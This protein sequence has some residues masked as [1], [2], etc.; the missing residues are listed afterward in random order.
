MGLFT[1]L[2]TGWFTKKAI[3]EYKSWPASEKLTFWTGLVGKCTINGTRLKELR[4]QNGYSREELAE[5]ICVTQYII[6]GWEQGWGLI[7][8]SS[9]EISEMAELF[10]LSEDQLREEL[11]ANEENDS[12][13]EDDEDD[14]Y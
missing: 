2:L 11:D 1:R 5:K 6:Q 8:P 14:D 12:D 9:G 7:N 13:Y 3:R 4:E 10:H